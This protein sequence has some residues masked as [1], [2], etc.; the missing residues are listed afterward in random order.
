MIQQEAPMQ[1]NAYIGPSI[2]ITGEVFADEPLTIAG[3]I[4]GPITVSGHV[5]TIE[6]GA[7]TEADITADT[8]VISGD[9]HGSLKASVRIEVS[10]TATIEGTLS[11]PSISVA[12]GA[13]VQG[14]V[15]AEGRPAASLRLAS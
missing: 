5:L 1:K 11:A 6:A 13:L 10:A 7:H 9:S 15:E 12:D 3:R 8:I 2:H 4:S 14:R